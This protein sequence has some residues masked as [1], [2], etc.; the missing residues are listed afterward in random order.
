MVTE[1]AAAATAPSEEQLCDAK[2][3]KSDTVAELVRYR[4]SIT[5]VGCGSIAVSFLTT[6][7]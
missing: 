2:V 5:N 3:L 4:S 6:T 1:E 7:C